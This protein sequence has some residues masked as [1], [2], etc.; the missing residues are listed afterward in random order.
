MDYLMMRTDEP[1]TADEVATV[2][3]PCAGQTS[4]AA[5]MPGGTTP[6]APC[7]AV[8]DFDLGDGKTIRVTCYWDGED[9]LFKKGKEIINADVVRWLALPDVEKEEDA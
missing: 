2:P 1:R 6:A 3:R 5:W 9:F 8:A 7:D 4:L